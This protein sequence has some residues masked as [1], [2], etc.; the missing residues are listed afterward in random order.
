MDFKKIILIPTLVLSLNILAQD[1]PGNL[2]FNRV[3]VYNSE[4][5]QGTPNPTSSDRGYGEFNSI[6]IP[7]G[8]IWKIESVVMYER[9]DTSNSP[10][11]GLNDFAPN[12]YGSI[13]PLGGSTTQTLQLNDTPVFVY[14]YTINSTESM[15]KYPIWLPPGEYTPHCWNSNSGTPELTIHALEFNIVP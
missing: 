15:V 4:I 2:Q 1:T 8:K 9:R 6:T 5:N 12:I 7:D 10:V 11:S 13:T 14:Q 3:V